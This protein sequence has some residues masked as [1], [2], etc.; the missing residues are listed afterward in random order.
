MFLCPSPFGSTVVVYI[1]PAMASSIENSPPDT[2]MIKDAKVTV[3]N[4]GNTKAQ[5]GAIESNG[6]VEAGQSGK[7]SGVLN[8]IISG[9]ALFSDGYNA[10]IIGYMEPL[11]SVL[12]N[13]GMS[14]T[15]KSRLSN[16]FLIGEIFGML[17]FGIL[18]DRVGR[19]TGVVA[20]TLFLVL[21]IALAAAAHGTSEL[22]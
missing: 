18:I 13:D 1:I 10:Q 20:A 17:F 7:S 14:P 4:W 21:G 22:G 9:L 16:S 2:S 12:Y 15:I 11:F 6:D 19:R 3:D 8:V 5:N